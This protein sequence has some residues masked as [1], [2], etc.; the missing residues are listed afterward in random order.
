MPV[1]PPASPWSRL[2][3]TTVCSARRGRLFADG[4]ICE[5]CTRGLAT[6]R[7]AGMLSQLAAADRNRRPDV[8]CSSAARDVEPIGRCLCG[9][10][11]VFARL[12]CRWRASRREGPR[13]AKLPARD[14]GRRAGPGDYALFV[15]RLSPEKGVLEML[16]SVAAA[17]A[18][19]SGRGWRRAVAR[20]DIA[21]W[22]RKSGSAHIKL[23][24]P[25]ERRRYAKRRCEERAFWSSRAAGTSR[26]AWRCWRLRPVAF[27]PLRHGTGGVPELVVDG[28]TG[29]L[30]DPRSLD[31]IG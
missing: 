15:G 20:R 24:G 26:L 22:L 16:E 21:A 3:T 10:E 27:Q 9:L 17:P 2:S 14:P 30:F 23:L 18:H 25:L 6:R 7:G 29:L 5:D 13:Q 8:E 19:S 28:Q 12:L 11:P 1:S 4:Q 31:G